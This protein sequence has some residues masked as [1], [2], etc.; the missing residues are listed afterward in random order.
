MRMPYENWGRKTNEPLP[1]I[2]L[3]SP[4]SRTLLLSMFTHAPPLMF[5]FMFLL[6]MYV[7]GE[8][9]FVHELKVVILIVVVDVDPIIVVVVLPVLLVGATSF[10]I[11]GR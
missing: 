6:R 5:V 9:I 1:E 3:P 7:P 10:N 2:L 8:V 4:R 11:D